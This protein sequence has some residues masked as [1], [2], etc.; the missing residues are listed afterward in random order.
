MLTILLGGCGLIPDT[1]L[2][3]AEQ[4]ETITIMTWNI[5]A[6]FDGQET[7]TEYDDYLNSTG[8]SEEKYQ[9]R[10]TSLG[11]GI[12]GLKGGAPDILALQELENAQILRDLAEGP[13]AKEGYGWTFFAGNPGAS[14]GLGVLSRFPLNRTNAHSIT[15]N[16]E[17]TPRP[18][19]ELWLEP[20]GYPLVLFINHWKSK[21]GGE[22]QTESLRRSSARV[23]ARRLR[24][25]E[26]LNPEIPVIIMGDLNEN[27]DEFYRLSGAAI[28]ALLPDDPKAAELSGF[29]RSAAARASGRVA[30]RAPAVVQDFLVL[31]GQK[32]PVSGYF[33]EE[34]LTLYSPWR[35]DLQQGSYSYKHS[36][37]TIDHFL[38]NRTL[39]DHQGWEFDTCNIL[40]QEPFASAGGQPGAYNPRTGTGLSDHFPLLLTLKL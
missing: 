17:T 23:I 1:E 26:E 16:G 6:L 5:Q 7:G 27:H 32:P 25:I 9:A 10:L 36:W 11:K 29:S 14:L 20:G 21:L 31:S 38:L 22:E 8:W 24:E 30:D 28:S 33:S 37:E 40:N 34:T 18:I 4:V 15:N 39:F 12:S 35:D 13:L 3:K 2:V 19:L